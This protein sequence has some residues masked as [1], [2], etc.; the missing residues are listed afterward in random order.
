MEGAVPETWYAASPQRIE[1][2]LRLIN[3]W[4][5]DHPVTHGVKALIPEW[6]CWLGER[7]GL[8][9]DLRERAVTAATSGL[10][11]DHAG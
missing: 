6:V 1:F 7:A 8:P 2:Q 5:P 10:S 11:S 4:V 9:E 3:D